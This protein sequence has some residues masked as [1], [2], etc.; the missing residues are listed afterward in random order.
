[1][2]DMMTD[3]NMMSVTGNNTPR[4]VLGRTDGFTLLE[5]LVAFVLLA[6]TV[7][8]ILQ[9]FSS[10]IKTLSLSED[11]ATAVVMAE[12]KMREVLDNEQLAENA[13]SETSPE[14]HRFDITVAKAYETRTRDLTMKILE[15]S[16]AMSWKMGGK[17]KFLILN[18]MKTVKQQV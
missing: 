15:I 18:T 1:M 16:I 8:I 17:D 6:T 4:N 12:S 13:W 5:V 9:L 10:G 7:T 11:Y 2:M 14:G 3:R